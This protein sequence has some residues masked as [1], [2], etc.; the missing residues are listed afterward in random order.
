[1]RN[2]TAV[3]AIAHAAILL[4]LFVCSISALAD[5]LSI[6]QA[7]YQVARARAE[8]RWENAGYDRAPARF[9]EGSIAATKDESLPAHLMDVLLGANASN[10]EGVLQYGNAV[11]L[12]FIHSHREQLLCFLTEDYYNSRI[13]MSEMLSFGESGMVA[14]YDFTYLLVGTEDGR[15]Q[16][17][18][19]LPN[20]AWGEMMQ[21]A[22]AVQRERGW[23][24]PANTV[25]FNCTATT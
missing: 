21:S 18:V 12:P 19:A 11:L 8:Q 16:H 17:R 9:D 1:M 4:C 5:G 7:R 20:D 24:N 2:A 3:Q 23:T 22:M 15:W 6:D 13:P 14:I 25:H 10:I